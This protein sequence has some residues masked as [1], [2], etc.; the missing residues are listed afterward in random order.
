MLDE[1][2]RVVTFEGG[3]HRFGHIEESIE[4]IKRLIDNANLVYGLLND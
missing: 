3:S 2:Y 4:D 1:H